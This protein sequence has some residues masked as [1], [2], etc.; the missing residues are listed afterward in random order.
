M[1]FNRF[2]LRIAFRVILIALSMLAFSLAISAK[3]FRFTSVILAILA[4]AQVI[5]LISYTEKA[6][7]QLTRFLESIRYSDFTVSFTGDSMGPSFA[8]LNKAFNE[9][10]AEFRR[11]KAEKEEHFN[12]LQTVVQHISIGIIAFKKNGKVDMFNNAVKQL[13]SIHHLRAIHELNQVKPGLAEKVINLKA[14]ESCVSKVFIDDQLMQLLIRATEFRLRGEDYVLVS[15]QDIRSELEEKEIESWQN[16]IRVLTHEINNSITPITSLTCTVNEMLFDPD[17]PKRGF[18]SLDPEDMDNVN[19]ALQTI[20]GRSRGLLNFVE[21]YRGLTRIPK[22]NFRYF[23]VKDAYERV[24]LL[25]KPGFSEHQI[26]FGYSIQ[27]P[28]LMLTADPDLIDQVLINLVLNAIDAVS[29]SDQRKINLYAYTSRNGRTVLEVEDTGEG[30]KP[31]ILDK[32]FMPFFTSKKQGT[33]I[34]L[35]LSRQIM[36]LHKGSISV[37]SRPGEGTRFTLFF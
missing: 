29:Q 22:P 3:E 35:S 11:N 31:D 14:G 37:N 24:T 4:I 16:L 26:E 27:P 17:N 28:D 6:N 1:E 30:I 36:H 15:L 25:M 34:G 32:I 10:V 23:L 12:Y 7:R 2:R 5:E 20:L 21:V 13:L 9:V 19:T 8:D 33:G 18:K